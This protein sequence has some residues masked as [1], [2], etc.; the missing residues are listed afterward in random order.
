MIM[1]FKVNNKN[2]DINIDT[3]K[4][5]NSLDTWYEYVNDKSSKEDKAVLDKFKWKNVIKNPDSLL[6]NTETLH[7]KYIRKDTQKEE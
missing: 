3:I 7:K 4:E 2:I 6:I 1:Y 5:L